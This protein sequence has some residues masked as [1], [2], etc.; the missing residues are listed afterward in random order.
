MWFL[1]HAWLI[2]VIPTVS[3]FLIIFFGKRT[4]RWTNGG[5]YIGIAALL[6]S[7]VGI[8]KVNVPAVIVCEPNVC[9]ETALL[10]CVEL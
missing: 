4:A 5:S 3:F 10:L 9:T 8:V 1:D 2:P 7:F 6:A